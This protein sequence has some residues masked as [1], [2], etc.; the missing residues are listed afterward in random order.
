MP[1]INEPAIRLFGG[2][3][4]DQ[5]ID[6]L[7]SAAPSLWRGT[8]VV[9]Q[10]GLGQGGI[11]SV[12]NIQ[13]L[14]LE[15]KELTNKIGAPLVSKT[16]TSF[17]DSTT[18][19]TWNAGTAQHALIPLTNVETS[20]PA[21][22]YWLVL[23]V[24]TTDSPARIYTA[25]AAILAIAEDG[26]QGGGNAP[27]FTQGQSDARYASKVAA[28]VAL[29]YAGSLT[30]DLADGAVRACAM[31]GDATLHPPSS[32]ADNATWRGYFLAGG[33]GRTLSLDGAI[34]V[35]SESSF[36]GSRAIA[37]GKECVVQLTYRATRAAW[38]LSSLEGDY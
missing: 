32:P 38:V 5:L 34:L 25:G 4:Q 21:G 19:E 35:P 11:Q 22:T 29:A 7:T 3:T 12:A 27:Y 36:A 23:S 13:S 15:I 1:T 30:P 28:P 2:F 9:F 26:A 37:S 6:L 8:D 14:T 16:V 24:V 10:I 33:G 17:D 20:V 18:Q 31:A